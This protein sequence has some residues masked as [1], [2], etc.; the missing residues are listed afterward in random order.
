MQWEAR[1]S[2]ERMTGKFLKLIGNII[3]VLKKKVTDKEIDL[4]TLKTHL[5]VREP[6]HE[7]QY[8]EAQSV[9]DLLTKVFKGCS[10]TNPDLLESFTLEFDLPE[11][12]KEVERYRNDL[13][14]YRDQVLTEDFVKEG[15]EQYD[16]NANIEVS[17]FYT[18]IEVQY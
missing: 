17:M 9:D 3:S 4:A 8:N 16:Q 1:R 15:L 11:V 6:D 18:D 5:I 7:E 13:E 14:D 12:E 2:F 10:F